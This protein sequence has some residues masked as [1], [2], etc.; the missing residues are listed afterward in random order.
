MARRLLLVGFDGAIDWLCVLRFDSPPLFCRL[1][2]I[3]RGGAFT[4]APEGMVESRQFYEPDTAVLVTEMR[5]AIGMLELRDVFPFRSGSDLAE[6]VSASRHELL[7]SARV[8]YGHVRLLINVDPR[9]ER[10]VTAGD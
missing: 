6:E 7:R 9:E 5:S 2:D 8:V 1:P 10:K 4:V 3:L